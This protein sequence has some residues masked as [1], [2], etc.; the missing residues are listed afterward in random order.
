VII[1]LCGVRGSGKDTIG[2]LLRDQHGFTKEAFANPLKEMVKHAFPAITDEDL[3]GPSKNR[4]REYGQ[5]PF[6]GECVSCGCQCQP[7]PKHLQGPHEAWDC[8]E[9]GLIYPASVNARIACQA[10]GTSWGRRLYRNVWIDACFERI[11]NHARPFYEHLGKHMIDPKTNAPATLE[12]VAA[13][14]NWVITDGRFRNEVARSRELGGFAVLLTR[15]LKESTDPHP[16]E[17]ELRT[18]KPEEFNLVFDNA[19]MAL[20]GLPAAVEGL[21][22]TIKAAG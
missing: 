11:K 22:K 12:A 17:A 8:P 19:S 1:V 4:E 9:C 21:L 2:D 14:R 15:G 6:S 16:S 18:M 5:Y 3:Y 10:L 13:G 7:I 20:E